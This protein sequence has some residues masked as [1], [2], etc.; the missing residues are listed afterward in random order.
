MT[1]R[2]YADSKARGGGPRDDSE[3]GDRNT[4]TGRYWTEERKSVSLNVIHSINSPVHS[5]DLINGAGG[6]GRSFRRRPRNE[7]FSCTT[8]MSGKSSTEHISSSM[9][10]ISGIG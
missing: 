3:S 8:V 4:R 6:E 7:C 9:R 2:T 5:C 1:G 10:L